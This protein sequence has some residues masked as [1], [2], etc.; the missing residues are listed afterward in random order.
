MNPDVTIYDDTRLIRLMQQPDNHGIFAN[1]LATFCDEY[2]NMDPR[3]KCTERKDFQ[4]MSDFFAFR[5]NAVNS[6]QSWHEP[7]QHAENWTTTVFRNIVE[8]G[9]FAWIQRYSNT[10]Y[11]VVTQEDIAHSHEKWTTKLRYLIEGRTSC[12]GHRPRGCKNVESVTV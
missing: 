6:Y 7:S 4:L 1:C 12:P 11:C 8:S 9:H 3:R 2:A 10:S 5:P